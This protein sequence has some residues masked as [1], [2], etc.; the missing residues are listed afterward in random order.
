MLP[1]NAKYSAGSLDRYKREH[2]F[3]DPLI[4]NDKRPNKKIPVRIPQLYSS[5]GVL[6][7]T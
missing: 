4:Q 2:K 5:K 1:N 7:V 3:N 6:S